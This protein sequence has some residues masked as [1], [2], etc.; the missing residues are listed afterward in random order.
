MDRTRVAAWV[1]GIASVFIALLFF[2]ELRGAR[3]D[4]P[5]AVG[6][7]L[8]SIGS[9]FVVTWVLAI[10]E[11]PL[12]RAALPVTGAVA[13]IFS[14]WSFSSFFSRELGVPPPWQVYAW[15][16]VQLPL[17]VASAIWAVRP[18][19]WPT[20]AVQATAAIEVGLSSVSCR[21]S[22]CST[23]GW[24]RPEF[25][26]RSSSSFHWSRSSADFAPSSLTHDPQAFEPS[27]PCRPR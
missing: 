13:V 9:P 23:T 7:A 11:S 22:A 19:L 27:L 5:A 25:T 21:H 10:P 17:I 26:A 15:L 14:T 6:S 3:L 18:K 20:V 4:D 8:L 24:L 2:Y 12:A 1:A 16:L